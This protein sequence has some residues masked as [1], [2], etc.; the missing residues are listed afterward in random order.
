[1]IIK[2]FP[3]TNE[4]NSSVITIAPESADITFSRFI[5]TGEIKLKVQ[6]TEVLDLICGLFIFEALLRDGKY[7]S[8]NGKLDGNEHIQIELDFLK[9][10]MLSRLETYLTYLLTFSLG[11]SI[12]LNVVSKG[13]P[14]ENT[15][16]ETSKSDGA[17]CLFSGGAD[18]FTGILTTKNRIDHT[19]GIFVSHAMLRKLVETELMPWMKAKG[20]EIKVI[21]IPK[22]REGVQQLRGFVYTAIAGI[23]AYNCGIS[24]III[25]EIGPVMFQPSYD[26]LDE[27]TITTHPTTIELTK[28]ILY[29]FYGK[30]FD[31]QTPFKMLTKSE[32]VS[33][34]KNYSIIKR[35]NSCRS[36]MFSNSKY[37][38]C[39]RCLG[40]LVRRISFIVA[41]I[42]KGIDDGYAWDV[43]IKGEGENV[44]GRGEEWR[45]G[46]ES[47]SDLFQ[48][49]NFADSVLRDSI[50][51]TSATKIDDYD[52]KELFYRFSLDVMAAAYLMYE[53]HKIGRNH[54]VEEIYNNLKADKLIDVEMLKRRIC[55]VRERKFTPTFK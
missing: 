37:P 34:V 46:K 24:K 48:I 10:E 23:V 33:L 11:T 18:S 44:K 40:C 4:G 19:T 42:K 50:P 2:I 15:V 51:S 27:V 55:E 12:T 36:T 20:I 52:L 17:I 28:K 9:S 53:D 1:M 14:I 7:G 54:L 39:G 31:I 21:K 16:L 41:G 13:Y 43:F 35:T 49:L 8:F 47:F 22:G 25:S 3:K 5:E 45:V 30:E 6:D 32:A 38:N 29:T 26:I